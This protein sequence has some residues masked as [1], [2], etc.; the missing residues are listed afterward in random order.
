MTGELRQEEPGSGKPGANCL[1]GVSGCSGGRPMSMVGVLSSGKAGVVGTDGVGVGVV[2]TG[3][4]MVLT[5]VAGVGM[6]VAGVVDVGVGSMHSI[7]VGMTTEG[8][9]G[10]GVVGAG[11]VGAGVVGAGVVGVGVTGADRGSAAGTA[12]TTSA[13]G[14]GLITSFFIQS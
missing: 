1:T 11:V 8:V 12:V 10:T 13:D 7:G 4:G 5:G 14:M 9:V 3:V 2:G 6:L